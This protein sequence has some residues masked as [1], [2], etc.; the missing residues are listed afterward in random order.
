MFS[1]LHKVDITEY[2]DVILHGGIQ[3]RDTGQ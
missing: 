2:L 3:M 1:M